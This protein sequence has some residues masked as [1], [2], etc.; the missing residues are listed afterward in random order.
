[1]SRVNDI[2]E[3]RLL[4]LVWC[5][6]ALLGG[7]VSTWLGAPLAVSAL[8]AGALVGP[9][10]A[11][12]AARAGTGTLQRLSVQHEAML[13][14]LGVCSAAAITGGL[15]SPL[16]GLL[17]LLPVLA[18]IEGDR[19][20]TLDASIVGLIGYGCLL[21]VEQFLVLPELAPWAWPLAVFPLLGALLWVML[22]ALLVRRGSDAPAAAPPVAEVPPRV[23]RTLDPDGPV[24]AVELTPLGRVQTISG[25]A[26]LLPSLKPGQL[27]ERLVAAPGR[28]AFAKRLQAAG[29]VRL[30]LPA[31]RAVRLFIRPHASGISLVAVPADGE[32][33]AIAAARKDAEAA[34]KARNLYFASLS[35]DLKTPLN[36]ILGFADMMRA[37]LKGPLPPAYRDYAGI[38]HESGEDLMLLVEDILDLAKADAG[39]QSLDIEPVDLAASGR[40]VLR[41]L[42]ATAERRSISLTLDADPDA[43]AMADAR[44]VRQIWQNLLSNALKYSRSGQ[45]VRLAVL[46]VGDAV[47]LCVEDEGEGMDAADLEAITE[48]FAQGRNAAGHGGTG[49]GL[50]V[51]RRFAELMGGELRL[52]SERGQGTR[53]RVSLPPAD[54]A[55]Y[56]PL[57]DAAE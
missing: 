41:Q 14:V 7:A 3:T 12:L 28:A 13:W 33:R 26:G 45:T 11:S 6:G 44:A 29:S 32:D 25:N 31:G 38:I 17:L 39:G 56:A 57:E 43:W 20:R 8:L 54:P 49:L 46:R 2:P 4:A 51:V 19:A 9:G 16:C 18:A 23:W 24:C 10:L 37:E 52:A 55:D 15:F 40:A 34:V 22:T 5:A 48:P 27:A 36:A 42:Q 35:H 30:V 1:M 21:L 47:E 50:T 53:V